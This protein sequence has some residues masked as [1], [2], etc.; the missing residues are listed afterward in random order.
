M[1]PTEAE[2][3][4]FRTHLT[5]QVLQ[6]A[7][8]FGPRSPLAKRCTT[9]QQISQIRCTMEAHEAA[10]NIEYF[11]NGKTF[12][13]CEV[14]RFNECPVQKYI[15]Q[16]FNLMIFGE[17]VTDVAVFGIG[18]I[19]VDGESHSHSNGGLLRNFFREEVERQL[20]EKAIN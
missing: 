19:E 14:V 6:A 11:V 4:T 1:A 17:S 16:R 18:G 12:S 2:L 13:A 8:T 3:I 9:G 5:H 20:V 7:F 10:Y 15:C